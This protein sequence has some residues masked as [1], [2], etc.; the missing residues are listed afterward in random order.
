MN[1][2]D[3][4]LMLE[5]VRRFVRDDVM[6]LETRIDETDEI[7][8]RIRQAAKEMGLFGTG[9]PEEYGGLGFSIEMEVRLVFELGYTTPAL[10]AMF[11]TNNGIAGQLLVEA[12]T[13]AQKREWLPSIASGDTI[14]SFGLTEPEAGSDPSTL[15]TRARRDGNGWVIDGYKR[16][17]TNSPIADVIVVFARTNPDVPAVRG[18]SAFL[19]PTDLPGVSVGPRDRKMG[20]KGEWTADVALDSVRVPS[21]AL[22]GEEGIGYH[23]AMR[24][25]GPG[26]VRIA[27]LCVGM[28]HRLVDE[29][30]DYATTRR[31]SGRPIGEFQLVQG[32]LADSQADLYAGRALALETARAFDDGSDTRI[33]PSCAKYFCAEMVGRVADR[34]VQ[35]HGGAGYM[36]GEAVERMYRDARLFRLYEGTSQIHQIIIATQSL[37]QRQR[38][39]GRTPR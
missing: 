31:Q 5:T 4:E 13:E 26:R 34:A 2:A 37:R 21:T 36:T 12:G 8:D 20:Q 11:G 18:I 17:I 10:R 22:V 33:G 38:L 3:R 1:E 15:T 7:P 9:I 32:M 19:V 30:L 24:S 29:S 39:T 25:L 14:V 6:P 23:A 27:G 35:I 16:Y 28:A